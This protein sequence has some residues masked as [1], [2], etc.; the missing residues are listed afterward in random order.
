MYV[1]YICSPYRAKTEAE[2]D[3]H[4]EYAQALTRLALKAGLAPITPHLY[5]TQAT[6]DSQPAERRA[7]L[8]A[9]QELLLKCDLMI[10]GNKY[11]VSEGME[12]E[13]TLARSKQITVLAIF[14]S[15]T[16]ENLTCM[17]ERYMHDK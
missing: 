10:I 13:I 3:N 7:G 8:T 4:I 12:E 16:P 1:A 6:D 14:D 9:G 15:T 17:I 2:L 5:L 11:G